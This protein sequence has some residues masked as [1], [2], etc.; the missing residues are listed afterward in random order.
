M[1]RRIILIIIIVCEQIGVTAPFSAKEVSLNPQNPVG[2]EGVAE[3]FISDINPL[4]QKIVGTE[5]NIDA[6]SYISIDKGTAKILVEKDSKIRIPMASTTKIMTAIIVLESAKLDDVVTVSPKA[7]STYGTGIGL[8]LG[9]KLTVKSLLYATLLNSSNDSAVALAEY[10]SGSEE[11]F[12][13]LMNKKAK[14]ISA[15]D[16][17]FTNAAGLD[18][19]NHF[20]T[21]SDMAIIT[22]YALLNEKFREIVKT[23]EKTI[24]SLE[25][26]NHGLK[27]SNKLMGSEFNILGVKTGYTSEAGECLITLAE[28]KG[29]EIITIVL[30][31]PDRFRET[32][33]L[34]RWSFDSY[35]W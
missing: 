26:I 9:E 21:V 27:N 22:R 4:P 25:G 5:L 1:L 29:H 10:V 2:E 3:Y 16:C 28:D 24:T 34:L 23:R 13:K 15:C 19:P 8:R 32:K 30:N 20:S 17:N 11:E 33:K 14:E 12:A 6:R 7:I 35:K 31:A 18:D